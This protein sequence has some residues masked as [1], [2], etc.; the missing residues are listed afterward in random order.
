VRRRCT[1]SIK[2]ADDDCGGAPTAVAG[3]TESAD[4]GDVIEIYR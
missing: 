2:D 4:S 1:S 3:L